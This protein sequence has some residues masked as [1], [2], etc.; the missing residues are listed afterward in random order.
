M[1][2][3]KL[4]TTAPRPAG[5]RRSQQERSAA[6]EGSRGSRSREASPNQAQSKRNPG[7]VPRKT[8]TRDRPSQSGSVTDPDPSSRLPLDGLPRPRKVFPD[9]SLRRNQSQQPPP[10]LIKPPETGA[11]A[12][13]NVPPWATPPGRIPAS[14]R[15]TDRAASRNSL[16]ALLFLR[17]GVC[18]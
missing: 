5:S 2:D 16:R 4:Q 12:K 18:D 3:H 8:P 7:T 14:R 10:E 1:R 11:G 17:A 9:L 15:A 13:R 6:R